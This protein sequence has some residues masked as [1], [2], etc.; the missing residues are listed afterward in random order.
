VVINLPTSQAVKYQLYFSE[1]GIL[2][3]ASTSSPLDHW[4]GYVTRLP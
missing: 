1:W 3:G 2:G 4:V